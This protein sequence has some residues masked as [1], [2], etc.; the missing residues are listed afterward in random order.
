MNKTEGISC[1]KI[2]SQTHVLLVF[3]CFDLIET[4]CGRLLDKS[5]LPVTSD[6]TTIKD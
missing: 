5:T 2:V 3:L 6:V 4:L 1:I